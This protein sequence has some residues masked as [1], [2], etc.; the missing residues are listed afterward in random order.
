MLPLFGNP[1]KVPK[2]SFKQASSLVPPG[3]AAILLVVG[4]SPGAGMMG[5]WLRTRLIDGAFAEARSLTTALLLCMATRFLF[6]DQR[7]VS[8]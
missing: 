2:G 1:Q 4:S 3:S 5:G 7:L 8:C 6:V